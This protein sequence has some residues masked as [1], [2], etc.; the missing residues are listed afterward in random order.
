MIPEKLKAGDEVRVI[1]PSRSMTIL[2][3]DCKKIATERLENLGLKVTFGKNVM[4]ADDDYMCASI[5]SRIEDLNEAFRNKNVKAILTVIGGFNSNQLLDYIDYDAI[6]ENPKIFCGFSDITA[7]A[8]SIYA[9][10]GLVTYSGP[11]YSSFGMLKGFEY[12]LEYFKKMFFQSDEFDIHSSDEWSDDL[13]FIDQENREFIKNDGMFVINEGKAEGNI[14]GGNLCTLNLLQGTKYMPNI[15]NK[16]LFLE[17]DD[18]AGKIFLMEFDRNLQSLI[19]MP[20]FKSVKGIVL[21]RSQKA[22]SMTKEKWIK[23]IKNKSELSN[24]PVIAG[25]DFGHSTPIITYPIGGYVRLDAKN[26]NIRLSIKG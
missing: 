9:R 20:E 18:L 13:W 26:N 8:N 1:A 24:I 5:K 16:I 22:T 25:V 7:L 3:D 21:G 4:E 14:V 19:H 15:E 6:K 2:K 23:L 17:D 12:T 10:T 11:H